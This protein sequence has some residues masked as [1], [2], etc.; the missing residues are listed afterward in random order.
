MVLNQILIESQKLISLGITDKFMA[1]VKNKTPFT[2]SFTRLETGETITKEIDAYEMF[3][4]M[5]E[6][7]W[8]YAEPG[9]L[10]TESII[11]IY[12][13]VMMNLN[14]QEQIHAQKNLSQREVHAFLVALT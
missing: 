12:L 14:M 4:K 1:A 3:H 11:G 8:D 7:N 2:L 9:M 13:V 10:G 5:C 6:M